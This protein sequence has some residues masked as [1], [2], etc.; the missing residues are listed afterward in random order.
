MR[1]ASQIKWNQIS[2]N[3]NP[4]KK[5]LPNGTAECWINMENA[6]HKEQKKKNRMKNAALWNGPWQKGKNQKKK[7]IGEILNLKNITYNRTNYSWY[8]VQVIILKCNQ[9]F[10]VCWWQIGSTALCTTLLNNSNATDECKKFSSSILWSRAE[11]HQSEIFR[12]HC[13]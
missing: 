13:K 12:R 8:F 9:F 4:M 1:A 7:K 11:W 3:G 2:T 5:K 10:P 6:L